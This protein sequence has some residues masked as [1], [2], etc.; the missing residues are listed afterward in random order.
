MSM[1]SPSSTGSAI[2]ALPAH[3]AGTAVLADAIFG[4]RSTLKDI[5]LVIGGAAFVGLLA[6][7]SIPMWPV[8]ITG[9]T[10]GVMVAG[11]VLGSRRAMFAMLT[12]AVGGLLGIPW[13]ADMGGGLAYALKPSFGFIIGFI[14]AAWVVGWLSERRWDRRPLA[15]LTAFAVASLIP[16]IVGIPWMWVT[17]HAFFGQTLGLWATLNAGLIPFIPGG[18]VKWI[19]SAAIVGGTWKLIGRPAGPQ[20]N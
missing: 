3:S 7:V 10:L 11:A 9:Q 12:Y 6:Q 18:I 8:S 4:V 15:A 2:H 14:A 16:F 13:F 19:L 5:A 17:L 1:S 20:E